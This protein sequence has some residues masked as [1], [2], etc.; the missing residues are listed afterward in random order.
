MGPDHPCWWPRLSFWLAA[1]FWPTSGCHSY[2][3]NKTVHGRF[4]FS[5]TLP[6]F[7][8]LCVYPS[9]TFHLKWMNEYI[10][11]NTFFK[12]LMSGLSQQTIDSSF[13][14]KMEWSTTF[15]FTWNILCEFILL[16]G[17]L[18]KQNQVH[19]TSKATLMIYWD[20]FISWFQCENIF[21]QNA[22]VLMS[23]WFENHITLFSV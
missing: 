20:K 16:N 22:A 11:N 1:F 23:S 5:L 9:V 18:R 2:L 17:Q 19:Q 10:N 21:L 8:S 7:L 6:V 3:E 4:F 14:Q 12:N 15:H 13:S